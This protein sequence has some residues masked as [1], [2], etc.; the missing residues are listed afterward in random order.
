[1]KPVLPHVLA[2]ISIA[3]FCLPLFSG[4]ALALDLTPKRANDPCN[5]SGLTAQGRATFHCD[6]GAN[7]TQSAAAGSVAKGA[8]N[9]PAAGAGSGSSEHGSIR[10][11][12]NGG[13]DF[14]APKLKEPVPKPRGVAPRAG[15]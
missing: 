9:Q 7:G 10:G 8:G 4:Q 15:K 2:G 13:G 5:V 1:M 6:S 14:I 3:M 11:T 12:I